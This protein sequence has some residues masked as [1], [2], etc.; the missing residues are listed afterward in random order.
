MLVSRL[1]ACRFDEACRTAKSA[2]H[3][4]HIAGGPQSLQATDQS[5]CIDS[6]GVGFLGAARRRGF[7]T[8]G[9]TPQEVSPT[10]TRAEMGAALDGHQATTLATSNADAGI[11]DL[12]LHVMAIGRSPRCST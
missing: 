12:S 8:G 9:Q 4:S 5:M 1:E 2:L 7:G 11:D 10:T 6:G 3:G